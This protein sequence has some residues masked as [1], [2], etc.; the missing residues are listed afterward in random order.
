M[1]TGLTNGPERAEARRLGQMFYMPPKPCRNGHS[2]KRYAVSGICVECSDQNNKP[3]AVT[4]EELTDSV[5]TVVY[6]VEAG[7]YVKVGIAEDVASRFAVIKTNCPLPA[8][9]AFT[10][11]PLPRP[12]ARKAEAWCAFVLADKSAQGE[13][14]KCGADEAVAA[15]NEALLQDTTIQR[16]E[17]MQLKLVANE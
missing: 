4:N 11:S 15:I 6:V 12:W 5:A 1:K 3:R 17:P 7:G 2:S 16:E 14:F 8:R 10:T 13:W 9:V